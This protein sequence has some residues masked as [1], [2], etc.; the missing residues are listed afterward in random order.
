[1]DEKTLREIWNQITLLLT[2]WPVSAVV[3]LTGYLV[4]KTKRNLSRS[5]I[6]CGA[7]GTAGTLACAGWLSVAPDSYQKA[8]WTGLTV[9]FT[10]GL[11][12]SRNMP[13]VIGL[14]IRVLSAI[15]QEANSTE[16]SDGK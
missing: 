11:S 10:M 5:L 12:G 13:E 7:C 8:F 2:F 1:V 6:W 14:V 4:R 15:R 3:G 9:S 16:K